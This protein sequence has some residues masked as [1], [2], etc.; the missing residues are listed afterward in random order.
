[1]TSPLGSPNQSQFD[2]EFSTDYGQTWLSI[3]RPSTI[4]SNTNDII[5][6]QPLRAIKNRFY[7]PLHTYLSLSKQVF[8][9]EMQEN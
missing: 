7:L 5:I 2:L 4:A 9:F 1:M 3:N 8:T 6:N